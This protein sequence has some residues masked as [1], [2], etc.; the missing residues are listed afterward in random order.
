MEAPKSI[1]P[2]RSPQERER[3]SIPEREYESL[4][5]GSEISL[6]ELNAARKEGDRFYVI[7]PRG[8]ALPVLVTGVTEEREGDARQF[9][10]DIKY[11]PFPESL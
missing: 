5:A 4:A 3:L 10:I 9:K 2:L 6:Y 7:E 1:P 8:S 11:E